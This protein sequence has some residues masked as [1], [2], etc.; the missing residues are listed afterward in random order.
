MQAQDTKQNPGKL[1]IKVNQAKDDIK[2]II[3]DFLDQMPQAIGANNH[4]GS[5]TTADYNTILNVM[6]VLKKKGLFFLDS[7]TS[8]ESK[9][10]NAAKELNVD[11][12]ARDIF[13]DVPDVSSSTINQKLK[14]LEKY[15]GRAE[16]VIIIS[17]C[18]NQ[19][20]LTAMRSFISHLKG[21]G[22]NLIPLSD[23][24]RKFQTPI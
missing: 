1:Y 4:M 22:I 3:N 6:E 10:A 12:S 13:L 5:G 9:V 17:H 19:A 14:D 2:D 20:K 7:R 16:P 23:A 21:M 24:V 15:R 11:Y 8:A 18:H